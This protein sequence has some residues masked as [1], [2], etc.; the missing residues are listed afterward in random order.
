MSLNKLKDDHAYATIRQ[1]IL[2]NFSSGEL[3]TLDQVLDRYLG[4]HR[5]LKEFQNW[6]ITLLWDKVITGLSYEGKMHLY[7]GTSCG[8]YVLTTPKNVDKQI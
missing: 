6:D 2:D 3:I 7:P 4:T 5:S 1:F 8:E